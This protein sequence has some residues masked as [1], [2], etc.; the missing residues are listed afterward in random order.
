MSRNL[1]NSSTLSM[2]KEVSSGK[3]KRQCINGIAA[4][5]CVPIPDFNYVCFSDLCNASDGPLASRNYAVA[6]IVAAS[7]VAV[8]SRLLY[9]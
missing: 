7:I 3:A 4:V 5:E 9:G 2:Q 1:L 8:F 6:A